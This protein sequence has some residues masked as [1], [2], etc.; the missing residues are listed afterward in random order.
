[1][2]DYQQ[3]MRIPGLGQLPTLRNLLFMRNVN[4]MK[5]SPVCQ[6][7]FPHQGLQL[8]GGCVTGFADGGRGC[9][10]GND[11]D[12]SSPVQQSILEHSP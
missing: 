8:T 5:T 1:M 2:P 11:S 3:L 12:R 7:F 9:N 4:F 10:P 6:L